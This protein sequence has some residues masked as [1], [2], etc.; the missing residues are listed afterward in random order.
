[1]AL[2]IITILLQIIIQYWKILARR[3][4]GYLTNDSIYNENNTV[5]RLTFLTLYLI[6]RGMFRQPGSIYVT[7]MSVYKLIPYLPQSK[8]PLRAGRPG[9]IPCRMVFSLCHRVRAGSG[10]HDSIQWVPQVKR[11]GCRDDHSP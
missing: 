11:P 8:N 10:G 2:L 9:M 6:K 3:T 7:E 1:M 5:K 4:V